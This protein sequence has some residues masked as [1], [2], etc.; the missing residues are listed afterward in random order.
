MSRE[1]K[2]PLKDK[3]RVRWS[4]QNQFHVMHNHHY[5]SKKLEETD[6]EYD[7]RMK[8]DREERRQ[9]ELKEEESL[10]RRQNTLNQWQQE[11]REQRLQTLADLR[12]RRGGV[13]EFMGLDGVGMRST[14]SSAAGSA[15][16]GAGMTTALNPHQEQILEAI[17]PG[18]VYNQ[19]GVPT[20]NPVAA[21][22]AEASHA[23]R[24]NAIPGGK[25]RKYRNKMKKYSRK[26]KKPKLSKNKK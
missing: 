1:E 7:A 4:E 2:R 18:G 21:S 13:S 10:R 8:K 19:Y 14:N 9:E 15:G 11:H 12:H 24:W 22:S 16:G 26:H 17:H 3:K 23:D 20:T 25:S 5:Y 6:E